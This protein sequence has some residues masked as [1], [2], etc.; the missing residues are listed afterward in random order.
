MEATLPSWVLIFKELGV[1]GAI[2]ALVGGAIGFL[3]TYIIYSRQEKAR[4]K[5]ERLELGRKILATVRSYRIT[6]GN[7]LVRLMLIEPK[8]RKKYP[9]LIDK[10][11]A[12][13]VEAAK[14]FNKMEALADLHMDKR[15]KRLLED[16]KKLNLLLTQESVDMTKKGKENWV[17]SDMKSGKKYLR[18]YNRLLKVVKEWV[19]SE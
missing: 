6:I 16:I 10:L 14:D 8:D 2:G 9:D 7:D 4:I 17:I 11:L 15:I 1:S 13:F 18:K 19:D 3:S 12:N 5:R